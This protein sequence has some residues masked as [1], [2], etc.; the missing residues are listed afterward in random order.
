MKAELTIAELRSLSPSRGEEA[1]DPDGVLQDRIK[2]IEDETR[3]RVEK[4]VREAAAE[5]II[6]AT[7]G[8]ASGGDSHH[9]KV[10]LGV[11]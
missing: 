2:A 3:A 9:L 1:G 5:S 6:E 7:R 10:C 8:E 11:A 4:E